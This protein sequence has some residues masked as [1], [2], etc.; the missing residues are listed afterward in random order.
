MTTWHDVIGEEKDKEYFHAVRSFEQ[1][2]SEII[3]K[4]FQLRRMSLKHS[5]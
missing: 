3:I 2:A 1:K 5:N 4:C